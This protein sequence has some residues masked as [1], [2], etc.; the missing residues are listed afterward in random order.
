MPRDTI[1][2]IKETEARAKAIEAEARAK[3]QKM[4]EETESSCIAFCA[5][6]EEALRAELEEKLDLL[7]KK[8]ETL[9][10][11]NA[12]SNEDH[13]NEICDNAR[14]RVRGAVKIILQE[15]EKQCQ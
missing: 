7:R 11:R 14:L 10:R 8:S 6:E 4:I 15:I 1:T 12:Q 5:K 3:A 9:V 2:T 13:A